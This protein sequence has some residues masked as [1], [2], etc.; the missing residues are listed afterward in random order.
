[1]LYAL[2]DLDKRGMQIKVLDKK[3]IVLLRFGRNVEVWNE[4]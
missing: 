3:T 1:M 2:K 4:Q